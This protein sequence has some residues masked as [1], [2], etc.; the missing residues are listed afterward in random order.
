MFN[1]LV[2]LNQTIPSIGIKFS[3]SFKN[4]RF[5][6]SVEWSLRV[7]LFFIFGLTSTLI[8]GLINVT[9][10]NLIAIQK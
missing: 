10:T 1:R 5:N 3:D 7:L 6:K 9:K 2:I 4:R 8:S